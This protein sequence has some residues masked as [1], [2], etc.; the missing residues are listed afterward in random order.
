MTSGVAQRPV[1]G[2]SVSVTRNNVECDVIKTKESASVI[3]TVIHLKKF[4]G[5]VFT[6]VWF[7]IYSFISTGRF[8]SPFLRFILAVTKF[9]PMAINNMTS[10]AEYT[11][12]LVS[13]KQDSSGLMKGI[14]G[15]MFVDP[16]AVLTEVS[17][18]T[19]N[20]ITI[21]CDFMYSLGGFL[22]NLVEFLSF[23]LKFMQ[24][25]CDC[26]RNLYDFIIHFKALNLRIA[27]SVMYILFKV[28]NVIVRIIR[29]AMF[30]W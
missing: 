12:S 30:N 15:L 29:I 14:M 4:I 3:Q 16:R 18:L 7:A 13:R 25:Y 28:K 19:G 27:E 6:I 1:N 21:S 8:I 5:S 26:L 23:V 9:I 20:F 17:K 10:W 11:S 22:P 2:G 24:M